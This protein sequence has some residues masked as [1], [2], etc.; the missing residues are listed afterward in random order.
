MRSSGLWTLAEL[1]EY[2]A[3]LHRTLA[4]GPIAEQGVAAAYLHG[5]A[6]SLVAT[7][8]RHRAPVHLRFAKRA[9][10]AFQA[11]STLDH[12]TAYALIHQLHAEA[13]ELV[14]DDHRRF[15]TDR[16]A[17]AREQLRVCVANEDDASAA[18]AAR[19]LM[20][21]NTLATTLQGER[22]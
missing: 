8:A 21:W 5:G 18:L 9:A 20:H 13:A 12:A 11:L 6:V 22:Q 17:I 14:A 2:L 7:F 19:R 3:A 10:N 15:V 16:Q 4:G 1:A